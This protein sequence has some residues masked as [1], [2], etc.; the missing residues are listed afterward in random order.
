HFETAI[1]ELKKTG[2]NKMILHQEYLLQHPDGYKYSQYCFHFTNFVK[3][4]DVVMHLDH[5]PAD[6]IMID[7]AGK[8][9][10]YTDPATGEVLDC[11]FFVAVLPH[12]GF[13]FCYAVHSQ[14]IP[15]FIEA[16]TQALLYFGGAPQTILCD[17]LRSAVTRTCKVEPVFT[18]ACYQ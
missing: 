7:F 6:Q 12:S 18:D 17:N 3:R 14:K 1:N 10:P 5:A 13:T 16:I 8:L 9:F 11:Q 15:D 4:R 2:V